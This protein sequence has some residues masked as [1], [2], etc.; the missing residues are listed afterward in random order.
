MEK[1]INSLSDLFA[2]N[3]EKV[4][5]NIA[6]S[7]VRYGEYGEA[8]INALKCKAPTFASRNLTDWNYDSCFSYEFVC[9]EDVEMPILSHAGIVN[10]LEEMQKPFYKI[11]LEV[12]AVLPFWYSYFSRIELVNRD[13]EIKRELSQ[14][15][16]LKNH[17]KLK[18]IFI[19][20]LD[21]NGY[22][23]IELKTLNE[24]VPNIICMELAEPSE[25]T[26]YN[27]LFHD[28]YGGKAEF[29]DAPKIWYENVKR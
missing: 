20:E 28:T 3:A 9:E 19:Q 2:N 22:K 25:V 11:S 29:A 10:C 8:M 4:S 24:K 7:K 15:A 17:E 14:S 5:A 23:E 26:V 18:E 1:L 12:S 6:S 27:C 13:S 21:E 16:F